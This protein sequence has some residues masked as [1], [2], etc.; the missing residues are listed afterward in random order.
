[1][2]QLQSTC[3]QR[4]FASMGISE[5]RAGLLARDFSAGEIAETFLARI[6]AHDRQ[7][8]AYLEITEQQAREAAARVDALVAQ[9]REGEL[10]PLAGVP[11]AFKDNMHMLGT[12]TTCA[13]RMLDGFESPFTADCVR[14]MIDAG[15][16]PLGKL[17]LDEFAFGSSTETSA[18]AK[19]RNPW[20]L[21][22]APGGSSGGSA[23]AAAAGLACVSLGSDAG[24][25]I[26][27][28]G[29]FCGV[30]AV[31]P[32]YGTVSPHGIAAFVDGLDQVGPIARSVEDAAV[33]MNVIADRDSLRRAVSRGL[34]GE[35]VDFTS[36]LGFGVRGMHI[37][38]VSRFME[39]P[40]LAGEVREAVIQ[41]LRVLESLGAVLVELDLPHADAAMDAYY[42]LGPRM[43]FANLG[44][45]NPMRF[46]HVPAEGLRE[47]D[48]SKPDFGPEAKRRI[49]RGAR[50]LS[51]E[52]GEGLYREALEV[53]ALVKQDYARAFE[54]V[55]AIVAPVT[56]RTAFR[57]GEVNDPH[58]MHLS[59]MFTVSVN[60][61][62][63]GA[64][65]MPLGLARDSGLPVGVQVIAPPM[66]DENML[67]VAAALEGVYGRAPL[68]PAFR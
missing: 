63:N 58:E 25:S 60:V 24:G 6:E 52:E 8:G 7:V 46:G 35:G 49:E 36:A 41:A 56:P 18:F 12:R 19:T 16:I 37:G 55:D 59:D 47:H 38:V 32:S 42:V 27:Q 66:R 13:S 30:V 67:R 68:A 51:S 48:R 34:V 45:F 20:D 5:I 1:M 14:R 26:R 9:G 40:R 22:R 65:S 15:A 61:A 17:N 43:A 57:F 31:K 54:R 4:D 29:A 33:V 28:P 50:L 23:A 44:D 53:Q 2:N 39:S 3:A 64:L 21:E 10:G 11:V 62:G